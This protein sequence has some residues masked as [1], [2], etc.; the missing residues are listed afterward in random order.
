MEFADFNSELWEQLHGA[1]GNVKEDV[2][3][4]MVQEPEV[5]E[6]EKVLNADYKCEYMVAF[7]NI[8]QQLYHQMTFYDASYIVLPY[9][10]KAFNYWYEKDD[11]AMQ[12]LFLVNAGIIVSTDNP[13]S[14]PH[15]EDIIKNIPESLM[16]SYHKSILFFK[17]KAE[18]L[19]LNK[20][21]MLKQ[22]SPDD[23]SYIC[24]SLL[25]FI[26]EREHSFAFLLGSFS[27]CL[28]FCE[29]CGFFFEDIELHYDI[30]SNKEELNKIITPAESVI[31]KWDKKSLDNTYIWLSN[32]LHLMGNDFD[33]KKLSYFYGTFTCPDCG[34]KVK[35]AIDVYIK[36]LNE[37]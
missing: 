2:L 16:E 1:Y 24:V 31:G 8:C 5:P 34:A 11:F 18:E 27:S 26:G 14:N 32:I 30:K 35:P 22:Y 23:I 21:D 33:V 28:V 7:D 3:P 12:V 29:K 19:L 37:C 15:S 25:A 13:F 10:V 4:L 6:S 17:E 20:R 9:L 36:A